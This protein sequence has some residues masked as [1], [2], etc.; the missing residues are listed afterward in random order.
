MTVRLAIVEDNAD[1]RLLLRAL[2][3]SAYA[4]TEYVTG[5][6]ALAGLRAEPPDLVLMD[7]SLPE[8]DGVEVLRALKEGEGGYDV[9]V[10]AVTA[11]AMTGDRERLLAAGFVGYVSKPIVDPEILHRTIREGLAS[12]RHPNVTPA[13]DPAGPV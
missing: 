3:S 5:P 9:P 2:L 12:K 11:H 6:E 4:L 1:N 13:A 7:I 10:V 8:M